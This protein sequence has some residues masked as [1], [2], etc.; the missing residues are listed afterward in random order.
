MP[1]TSNQGG[2]FCCAFAQ[3]GSLLGPLGLVADLRVHAGPFFGAF[4]RGTPFRGV[5]FSLVSARISLLGAPACPESRGR[6]Q[7]LCCPCF[8]T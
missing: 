1:G 4:V 5:G 2:F 7:E 8:A 3:V 6:L